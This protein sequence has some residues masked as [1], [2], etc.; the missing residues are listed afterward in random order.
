VL[1]NTQ[2]TQAIFAK[3]SPTAGELFLY[4][5]SALVADLHI[6]G[7]GQLYATDIQTGLSSGSVLL[8]A[9]DTGH[10]IPMTTTGA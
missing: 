5:G 9:Y 2:A 10:S 6:S 3:S 4:D 1:N 7:Q 8:T